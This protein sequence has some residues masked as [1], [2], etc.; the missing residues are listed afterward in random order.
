MSCAGLF[1]PS[2]ILD[3]I[4]YYLHLTKNKN[5]YFFAGSSIGNRQ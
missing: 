5:G 4:K 1:C 2:C 3:M